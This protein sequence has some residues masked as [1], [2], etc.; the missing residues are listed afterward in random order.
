MPG[1][2]DGNSNKHEV[3]LQAVLLADS[4]TTTFRP[5]TL[6]GPKVLCPLNNATMLDYSLDFLTGVGV[7]EVVVFCVHSAVQD[8]VLRHHKG[9]SMKIQVVRDSGCT[10][11]GDALR[12]LDKRNL[13]QS[14]P[15]IL[16]SGDIITNVN[17]SSVLKSHKARYEKDNSAI[18]TLL[19]QR[20]PSQHLTVGL[21]GHDGRIVLYNEKKDGTCSLPTC[22]VFQNSKIDVRCDLSNTGIAICSPDVLARFSDEFDYRQVYQQFV[23]NSVAEEEDGLQNRMY[24]HILADHEYAA[25]IHDPKTYHQVSHDLLRRWV[26]PVVPDNS[27]NTT[28]R[29][30]FYKSK[31]QYRECQQGGIT[32]GRST[33]ID[34]NNSGSIM[35]GSHVTIG[36]HCHLSDTTVLG[37]DVK[38]ANHVTIQDS[39]IWDNV[40]IESNVTIHDSI[41]CQNVIIKEGATIPR[42]CIIGKGCI[43]GKNIKLPEFTRLTLCPQDVEEEDDDEFSD[44]D[45]SIATSNGSS[46]EEEQVI[47]NHD[48]VGK[49]GQGRVWIPPITSSHYY[50]QD[51]DEDSD[52]D[53]EELQQKRKLD[54]MKVQSMGYNVDTTSDSYQQKQQQEMKQY[55]VHDEYQSEEEDDDSTTMIQDTSF[56]NDA[57]SSSYQQSSATTMEESSMIVGRQK[58]VNVV[59]QFKTM[60]LEHDVT[61]PIENLAIELNSYKFSQNATFV[62]VIVGSVQAIIQRLPETTTPKQCCIDFQNELKHWKPLL[63]RMAYSIVEEKAI[64]TTLQTTAS[65][66]DVLS[67]PPAF[68]FMLQS[69]FDQEVVTEEAILSWADDQNDIM[70]ENPDWMNTPIG[71]L[72]LQQH[73]QDFLQWL[74]EDSESDDDSDDDSADSDES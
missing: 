59:Q 68:R 45:D 70:K 30:Q 29:Y 69:L 57:F 27:F 53:D 56:G 33:I 21:S 73:T 9:S 37:H 66:S 63:Q 35:I 54:K 42:G 12:E 48:V 38:L 7:K 65:T 55:Y 44:D 20:R 43:V 1:G 71:K 5:L 3:G 14:N 22:F 4:F 47:S 24:S 31:N 62:D 61:S 23:S 39:H 60:C 6:D 34:K 13:I 18:M 11:A 64:V 41:L 36:E 52:D 15:F 28:H 16:M 67:K 74:E 50:E 19:F 72:F 40:I 2:G 49:D 32:I 25:Q 10:N 17:L 46:M 8:Y 26:Y 51:D 58:G